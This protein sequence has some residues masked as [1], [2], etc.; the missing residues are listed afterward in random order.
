MTYTLFECLKEKLTELLPEVKEAKAQKI[1]DVSENVAKIHIA[2]VIK[3]TDDGPQQPQ[4]KKEQ[5]TK[6]Q[7]R[8]MWERTDNKGNRPRGWNW[9][10]IIKH[11]SQ[12]GSKDD[13]MTIGSTATNVTQASSMTLQ[14]LN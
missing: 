4:V 7:K 1:T 13:S 14:P 6:A 3:T 11:L 10:D 12:T 9:V 8:R 2:P 5:L